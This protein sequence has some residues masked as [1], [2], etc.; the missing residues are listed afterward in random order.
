MRA[1][2]RTNA[3]AGTCSTCCAAATRCARTA[4]NGRTHDDG[5]PSFR[6]EH[7]TRANGLAH[8]AAHDALSDVRAT[9]ALARLV[10]TRQP[11]LWDFCLRL[12]SKHAVIEEIESARQAGQPFL[13]VSG[14]YGGERGCLAVVWPLAPHPTNRNELIVWDLAADPSELFGLGVDEIRDAAVQPRRRPA[15]PA[16][17]GCRSR[18]STST[19]RRS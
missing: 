18:P 16:R 1:N 19:G 10:R 13:H 11:R 8:A 3:G 5:Q 4:S 6:L 15:R 9:I 14:M 2:G 17:R 12:R 7:L